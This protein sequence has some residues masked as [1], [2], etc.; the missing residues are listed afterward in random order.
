M[1]SPLLFILL[2]HGYA[3]I[4]SSDHIIM[5]VSD[6][7]VVVWNFIRLFIIAINAN[8]N[9][10]LPLMFHNIKSNYTR[11]SSSPLIC[12]PEQYSK[13]AYISYKCTGK[14]HCYACLCS[15]CK[16]P[17]VL[18]WLLQYSRDYCHIYSKTYT[19]DSWTVFKM[20]ITLWIEVYKWQLIYSKYQIK[21]ATSII[22]S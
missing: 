4:Y 2:T 5:F 16:N 7:T 15:P 13:S 8:K 12:L 20:K 18:K 10:L 1:L 9:E 17:L 6:M 22:V 14:F 19:I 21:Y 11:V 3:V